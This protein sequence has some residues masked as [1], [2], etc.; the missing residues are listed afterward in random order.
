MTIG[1][2]AK[3]RTQL[4]PAPEAAEIRD[5]FGTQTHAYVKLQPLN[6]GI[7]NFKRAMGG[8]TVTQQT[9]DAIR[10]AV[11]RWKLQHLRA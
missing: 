2:K 8:V 10:S 3:T 5:L 7:D 11:R 1:R 6:V 9:I 4:L